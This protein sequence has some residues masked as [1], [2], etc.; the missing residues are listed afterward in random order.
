MAFFGK[1]KKEES[2]VFANTE[3]TTD[4]NASVAYRDGVFE[5]YEDVS[6][7]KKYGKILKYHGSEKIFEMSDEDFAMWKDAAD[8]F[9]KY[10]ITYERD[11]EYYIE[12]ASIELAVTENR[13]VESKNN[14]AAE[15]SSDAA[16]D[17]KQE[18]EKLIAFYNE[19]VKTSDFGVQMLKDATLEQCVGAASVCDRKVI[20]LVNKAKEGVKPGEQIKVQMPEALAKLSENSKKELYSRVMNLEK[21][22]VV[23][24]THTKRQHSAGGNAL[25]ALDAD[26]A[27]QIISELA[28]KNQQVYLREV[29]QQLISREFGTVISNGL[30]GAR[31]LYKYGMSTAVQFT[32]QHMKTRIPF[33]EN[34]AVRRAMGAFFQDL[35]NGVPAEKLKNSE[36]A[37]YDAFFRA[38]F[39]QPCAKKTA[40]D[41]TKQLS[42]CIIRDNKNN[43]LL[44]LFTTVEGMETSPSCVQF[45]QENPTENGYKKWTFDEL[46]AEIR[47]ENAPANGFMIDKENIPVPFMGKSLE[48]IIKLKEVW[49]QNGK[50]FVKKPQ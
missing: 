22:Y 16:V 8:N 38:T 3:K 36:F 11:E 15:A 46:I 40:P 30:V 49:E 37:M 39:I 6:T 20:E 4:K 25:V 12:K 41:G 33:P 31:F 43:C 44:D 34:I 48:N 14:S 2:K 42:V 5:A 47:N 26:V 1:N 28:S 21:I 50:T 9:N 13:G 18:V 17:T 27:Q 45:K 29:E 24:S 35:R 10:R 23:Y 19:A 32:D 7:G